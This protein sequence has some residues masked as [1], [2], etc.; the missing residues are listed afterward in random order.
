MLT[1]QSLKVF[2]S[3]RLIE[4]VE[5]VMGHVERTLTEYEEEM[6]RRC[7]KLL[8][9]CPRVEEEQ[10]AAACQ[11]Q[12]VVKEEVPEEQEWIPSLNQEDPDRP[13][14]KLEKQDFWTSKEVTIDLQ[15]LHEKNATR[16][17]YS[18][19][20]VKSED[21]EEKS[22][23]SQFHQRHTDKNR[24]EE[25]PA[26]SSA[27]QMKT[28]ADGEEHREPEPHRILVSSLS[29]S[30][31]KMDNSF[32]HNS[33]DSGDDCREIRKPQTG[34]KTIKNIVSEN[35][36]GHNATNKSFTCSKCGKRFGQKHHLLT[37]MRCHTGEKPFSCSFCGRR[38]TQKGNLTQHMTIHT[39]EK[40]CSC[41][42]CGERFSQK[43][44]LTQ[45][46]TVHTREN[47]CSCPIC[48]ENL[49][50]KGSLAQHLTMHTQE[51]PCSCPV[52]GERFAQK[53]NL[54]QHMT[55]H[56]REKFCW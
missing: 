53:G 21:A 2:I 18:S 14:I 39:R 41:P 9:T 12:L 54:T 34:L 42:V 33:K 38:F 15:G 6:E 55:V 30:D 27:D 36:T 37:H 7:G 29:G 5:E 13:C 8:D 22:H 32:E 45:H 46:L 16:F 44:N 10:R 24:E 31:D 26:S 48:G 17:Q 43:G 1:L 11:Q 28:E 35:D 40:P 51:K 52:C 49:A 20:H 23:S 56:A 50:Q 19:V 3:Q 47:P 25:P 4:A